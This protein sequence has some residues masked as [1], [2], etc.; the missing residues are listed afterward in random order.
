MQTKCTFQT[1]SM[2]TSLQFS[3][4]GYVH[5]NSACL[6]AIIRTPS[7]HIDIT[8]VGWQTLFSGLHKRARYAIL[9]LEIQLLSGMYVPLSIFT[10][11]PT[12]EVLAVESYVERLI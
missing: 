12:W 2:H 10:T 5:H 11:Q 9:E 6:Q 7:R 1:D 3:T 4:Q 8:L